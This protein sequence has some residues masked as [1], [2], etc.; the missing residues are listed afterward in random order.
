MTMTLY[1]WPKKE[2]SDTVVIISRVDD[3]QCL[4]FVVK[5]DYNMKEYVGMTYVITDYSSYIPVEKGYSVLFEKDMITGFD[6]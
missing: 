5:P 1:T 3:K 2:N 6:T 4:A